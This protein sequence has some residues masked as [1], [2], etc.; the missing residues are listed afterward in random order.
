MTEIAA[1][2]IYEVPGLSGQRLVFGGYCQYGDQ[3]VAQDVLYVDF[4]CKNV[5]ADGLY[6]LEF[7]DGSEVDW[8]G[9]KRFAVVPGG[10]RVDWDGAGRWMPA[11]NL[12]SGR[13]RIFD[14]EARVVGCVRQ[15][16]KPVVH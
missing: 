6:L 10:I 7:M 12:P 4:D 2:I 16:Y 13:V 9:C 14:A 5:S 11:A 8:I 1:P 3:V 15:V